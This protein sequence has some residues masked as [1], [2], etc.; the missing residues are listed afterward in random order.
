M[1]R[2][3]KRKPGVSLDLTEDE[4]SP[5]QEVYC[6]SSGKF[7]TVSKAKN[8]Y[9]TVFVDAKTG[10][11]IYIAHQ[12]KKHYPAVYLRVLDAIHKCYTP[13]KVVSLCR[14]LCSAYFWLVTYRTSSYLE[15]S[16][17]ILALLRRPFKIFVI[18]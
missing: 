16:T 17:I 9:F 8:R 13:I 7:R 6:D 2:K 3:R 4:L 5:W 18:S 14:Y 12:K 11:K 10:G 15:V 1:K